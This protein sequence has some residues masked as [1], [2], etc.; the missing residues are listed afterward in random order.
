MPNLGDFGTIGNR[1][2]AITSEGQTAGSRRD[3]DVDSN[4]FG[5][6]PLAGKA[7]HGAAAHGEVSTSA[8]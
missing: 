6:N 1:S 3:A 7:N 8:S 5:G 2:Q 4:G